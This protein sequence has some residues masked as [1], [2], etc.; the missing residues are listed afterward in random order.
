MRY[1]P[2]HPLVLKASYVPEHRFVLF[3][4]IGPGRHPCNGCGEVVEWKPGGRTGKGVLIVDHVDRNPMNNAPD[5]LVPSCTRCNVMNADR[6]VTDPENFRVVKG[7]TRLRGEQRNCE[8]CGGEF[9]TWSKNPGAGKGRFCSR[10][11][12]CRKPRAAAGAGPGLA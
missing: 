4:E 5:N 11:C 10:S 8:Y 12:A 7:G 6:V 2:G 9:V 3:E 1:A